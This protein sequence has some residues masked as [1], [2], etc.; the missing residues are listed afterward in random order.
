[1]VDYNEHEHLGYIVRLFGFASTEYRTKCAYIGYIL[2][3]DSPPSLE[4]FPISCY[5]IG[6]GSDT[7]MLVIVRGG[8]KIIDGLLA[9]AIGENLVVAPFESLYEKA[10]EYKCKR[11]EE[12][13]RKIEED[14]GILRKI[15]RECRYHEEMVM[16]RKTGF[17][18]VLDEDD[19]PK[20]PGERR[21]G[22]GSNA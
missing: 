5:L 18:E 22:D 8:V 14:R 6:F 11:I 9:D 19:S 4:M 16:L 10:R 20:N 7:L 17:L 15:A 1:M 12:A 21:G 2:E 3:W 13:L